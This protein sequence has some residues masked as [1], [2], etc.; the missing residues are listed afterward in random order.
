[1]LRVDEA[2]KLGPV[3]APSTQATDAHRLLNAGK[4]PT[5]GLVCPLLLY[6]EM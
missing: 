1:M 4:R 5:V 3:L 6:Q 2:E